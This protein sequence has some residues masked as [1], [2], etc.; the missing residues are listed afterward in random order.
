MAVIDGRICGLLN[1]LLKLDRVRA[2]IRGQDP[3]LDQALLAI[4][5]AGAA[6][7]NSSATGKRQAPQPEPATHCDQQ[8]DNT[9]STTSA[10]TLLGVTDRAIRRAITDKRLP[11][12]KLDGRYRIGRT[13]LAHYRD[14]RT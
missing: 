7:M 4:K 3:Q 13:E 8:D 5:L 12:T 14:T 2:E 1:Q 6:Y 11:A 9:I 10:A